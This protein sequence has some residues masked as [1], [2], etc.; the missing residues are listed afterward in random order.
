MTSYFKKAFAIASKDL[1]SEFRS[2]E[3]LYAMGMFSILVMVVISFCFEPG[4]DFMDEVA[5]GMFWIALV[6]A[7][8]LGLNKTFAAEKD[9]DCLQGVMLSPIDLSGLYLGKV[10]GNVV[11]SLMVAVTTLP[12]FAVFFRVDILGSLPQLLGV[13][14]LT[15]IAFVS[16]GTLV[17]AIS[18]GVKHGEMMLPLLL[19][20]F[21]API[22]IAAVMTTSKLLRGKVWA[23][24]AIWVY[25][26]AVGAVIYLTVSLIMFEYLVEE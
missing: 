23:D 24:Y 15:T 5:P 4:A 6:F 22:I 12:I 8:T 1:V 21:E 2:K 18:V 16:L 7:F 25:L 10:V 11:M 17:S 19:Y 26:L 9:Q 20:P 14:V 13:I 3:R